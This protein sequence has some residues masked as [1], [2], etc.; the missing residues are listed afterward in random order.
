MLLSCR[1]CWSRRKAK[2]VGSRK[3]KRFHPL[4]SRQVQK[5]LRKNTVFFAT[6]KEAE[7]AGFVASKI[8]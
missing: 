2:F 6:A 4:T 5:I 1:Y 8:Q 7:E 3:E